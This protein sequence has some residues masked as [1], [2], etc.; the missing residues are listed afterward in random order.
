[1]KNTRPPHERHA[2]PSCKGLLIRS[3]L[4]GLA[5]GAVHLAGWRESTG[6]LSG[7]PSEGLTI[8][9]T[10]IRGVLYLLAHLGF[11]VIAPILA[12]GAAFIKFHDRYLR[13]Y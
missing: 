8:E 6:F 7:T 3:A 4:L 1:M 10:A 2:A 9:Q 11:W 13:G 12:L 5:Y